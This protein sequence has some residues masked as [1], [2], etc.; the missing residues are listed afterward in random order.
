MNISIDKIEWRGLRLQLLCASDAVKT[1]A[2]IVEVTE[3]MYKS[4]V[5]N[6]KV[7]KMLAQIS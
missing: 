6:L 7:G 1:L 2:L 5:N 4:C 3:E